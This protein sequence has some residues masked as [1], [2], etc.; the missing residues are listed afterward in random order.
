MGLEV[1]V[2]STIHYVTIGNGELWFF[3]SEGIFHAIPEGEC[4]ASCY[5]PHISGTDA[6]AGAIVSGVEG[7]ATESYTD[8]E[9]SFSDEWGHRILTN[10]GICSIE[11]CLDHNGYYGGSLEVEKVEASRLPWEAHTDCLEAFELGAEC[12]CLGTR[13]ED[14]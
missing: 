14:F 13:L 8:G 2:G 10:K 9:D 11:M 1:L 4:S 7:I 3:T 12:G 5:I 6:L